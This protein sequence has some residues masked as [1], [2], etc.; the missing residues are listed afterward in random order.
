MKSRELQKKLG[1]D[2]AIHAKDSRIC[3]ASMHCHNLISV[4]VVTGDTKYALGGT[5]SNEEIK[6]LMDK[7]AALTKEER[8]YYWQGADDIENPITVYSVDED[9]SLVVSTTDSLEFPSVTHDGILIYSNTHFK[10]AKE[11][12]TNAIGYHAAALVFYNQDLINAKRQ[13]IES[14]SNIEK[15]NGIMESLKQQLEN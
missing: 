13:V 10:T 2:R 14:E 4:D 3:I 12:I 9:G 8:E 5:P 6:E 11:A 7:V 1:T 15:H